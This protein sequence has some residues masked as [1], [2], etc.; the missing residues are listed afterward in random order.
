[1]SIPRAMILAA[2]RGK[3]LR[4]ITDR[5]P[6][7]LVAVAGRTLLDRALDQVQL[8]G[9]PEAVVNVCYKAELITQHLARRDQP[10]LHII[11]ETKPL[12]TGGGIANAL[13]AL[14]DAPFFALNSDTICLDRPNGSPALTRMEAEWNTADYDVLLLLQPVESAIG[15]TGQGDFVEE[16]GRLRRRKAEERAPYVFTGIQMLHPRLFRACPSG[17][18][19]MN[20]LYDRLLDSQGYFTRMGWLIHEGDWLHVGDPEGLAQA[21]SALAVSDSLGAPA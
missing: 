14:G 16:A 5:I 6:K 17:A 13:S 19:S 10:Q 7:P 9:I 8:H 12:E 15:Y 20:V 18:F 11:Q 21:E 4:P 1:M 3:R 2:G